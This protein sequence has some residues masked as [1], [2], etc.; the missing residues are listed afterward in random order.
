M[1]DTIDY[2]IRKM[3]LA[4]EQANTV[5]K[6]KGHTGRVEE[7]VETFK[8]FYEGIS[9]VVDAEPL[10]IEEAIST[11]QEALREGNQAD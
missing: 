2:R 9:A 7:T 6:A 1:A 11:A 4:W 10:T 3:E 8:M 5:V